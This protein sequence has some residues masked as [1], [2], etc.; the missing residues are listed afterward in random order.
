MNIRNTGHKSKAQK[1][2][3]KDI[4]A[5]AHR[6]IDDFRETKTSASDRIIDEAHRE[7]D[8]FRET[9]KSVTDLLKT[10]GHADPGTVAEAEHRAISAINHLFEDEIKAKKAV[11]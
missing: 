6:E 11:G 9:K 4:I 8:D 7:M 1:I 3:N 2:R 5:Q 10:R